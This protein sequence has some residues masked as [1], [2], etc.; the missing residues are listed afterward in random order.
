MEGPGRAGQGWSTQ[1]R[2]GLG[3]GAR[4]LGAQSWGAG[5]EEPR[6]LWGTAGTCWSAV[7]LTRRQWDVACARPGDVA[8]ETTTRALLVIK[9]PK[10]HSMLVN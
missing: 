8:A 9:K 4:G 7:G 1:G 2:G 3:R 10:E 6:G 5:A